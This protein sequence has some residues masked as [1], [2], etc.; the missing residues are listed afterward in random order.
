MYKRQLFTGANVLGRSGLQVAGAA[1]AFDVKFDRG[2]A[3]EA[4]LKA[5]ITA[6]K[7]QEV[8][9]RYFNE[10]AADVPFAIREMVRQGMFGSGK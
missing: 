5:L 10:K 8:V 2:A 4:Q 6:A 1:G 3:N 7:N 9:N